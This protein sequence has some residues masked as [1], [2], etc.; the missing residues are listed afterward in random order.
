[1]RIYLRSADE[2]DPLT[3]LKRE[4]ESMTDPENKSITQHMIVVMATLEGGANSDRLVK[5]TGYSREFI[6]RI[7]FRMRKAGLWVGELVDDRESL[8]L[9]IEPL[10]G[11]F[12]HALVAQGA[13]TR[14][15]SMNG[16]CVYLDAETGEVEGEWSPRASRT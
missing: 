1:M 14:I 3:E 16:G 12:S 11:I 6:E 2:N 9:D 10:Y 5:R 15:P 4:V 13:I 8:D 7:E